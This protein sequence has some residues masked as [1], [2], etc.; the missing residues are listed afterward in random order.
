[1]DEFKNLFNVGIKNLQFL[2]DV[3]EKI[4][5]TITTNPQFGSLVLSNTLDTMITHNNIDGIN[6]VLTTIKAQ[7][8]TNPNIDTNFVKESY[9]K[10][11]GL[12]DNIVG[13]LKVTQEDVDKYDLEITK[14]Q[15]SKIKSLKM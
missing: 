11:L 5:Q 1:M 2:D 4:D 13:Q 6:S 3:K 15:Q 10:A 9:Q 12:P 8:Q 7:E 14:K